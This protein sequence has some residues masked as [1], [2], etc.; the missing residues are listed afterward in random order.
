V[1]EDFRLGDWIV[2]PQRRIIARG[3][4]STHIKPKPMSVLE[5]LAAADGAPVSR[6]ELFEAVWPGGIVSDE[7]LTKC[8]VELRK[9]FGDTARD[10][11]V[12]ETIPKL[13]FR[14]VVP[15]ELL[16]E[17]LPE[18]ELSAG[19]P[20]TESQ[21]PDPGK[22]PILRLTGLPLVAAVLVFVALLSY[23]I[24]RWWLP[25]AGDTVSPNTVAEHA[26]Y[27][28]EQKPG[29][30]V[31]PFVNMSSDPEN[32]Y[33]SDG[34]SEEILN[35]L[36]NTDRLPVTARTSSFQFKG[37]SRD[38]KEIGRL[39]GVTHILEGS[40]RKAG[41]SVR[42]SAQLIDA[43]TGMHVWSDVYQRK[44]S[45][46]FSLQNEIT[47]NIVDQISVALGDEPAFIQSN[48]AGTGLVTA[49]RTANFE[50]YDLYLK[51]RQ[52]LAS[53][54][55]KPVEQA[56][57]YFDRA[58]ALDGEYADA[59]AAKGRALY[60]LGREC[61]GHVQ[62]PSSV[63]PAAIAAFR[64]ALEIEPEHAFA[65]GWLGVALIHN[66]YKWAEGMQL[67]EQSLALNPNDAALL[68]VYGTRMHSLQMEGADEV[69]ERAYRLDPFG[70]APIAIRAFSLLEKGRPL[71][72]L[73]VM[74]TGLIGDREGYAPNC[75]LYFF[76]YTVGRLDAAEENIRKARLAAHPVDLT[77]DAMERG[78]ENRRGKG[79]P[80]GAWWWKRAQM[81]RLSYAVLF[82]WVEDEK[83]VVT[84]FDLAFEQR[85]SELLGT[86]FAPKPQQ[87]PEADWR[88][89]KDITGVTQFQKRGLE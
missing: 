39:L 20:S 49:R 33:F 73:T 72:A 64:K 74:E 75:Y 9:A 60:V 31:L 35:A 69:L 67:M 2:R 30:A 26:L 25:E 37:Q 76:N 24:S 56:A 66:D 28:L 41:G 3:D 44:W 7:T 45:D 58:I 21:P 79:P 1:T 34:M 38:I 36:A 6:N 84:A 70:L 46:I 63:Y 19:R 77:L 80:P 16:E 12:I 22:S 82:G 53:T 51:G 68:A 78:I 62:I 85:H 89:M 47:T 10:S 87:M 71:D 52:L 55:P 4:Q 81:E 18:E 17:E 40:V 32:E 65:M 29:I 27:S 43:V 13:G 5:C 15:V 88:R 14:L 59:W 50:A 54:N 23:G 8:V 48:D 11:R 86:L 61:H 83:T 42:V 57:G